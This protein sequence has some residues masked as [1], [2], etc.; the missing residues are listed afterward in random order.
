M[1]TITKSIIFKTLTLI[2]VFYVVSLKEKMY[3]YL[4]YDPFSRLT[5]IGKSKNPNKRLLSIKTSNPNAELFFYT[6]EFTEMF[7]HNKF[8]DKRQDGEWFA[9]NKI[10]I[11]QITKTYKCIP[12]SLHY[13]NTKKDKIR[14]D[15][16][17]RKNKL[18]NHFFISELSFAPNYQ[19]TTK[20]DLY[21]TKTMRKINKT[22]NGYS[23]GYWIDKKFITL[24]NLRKHLVK[25]EHINCPF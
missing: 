24:G 16:N 13:T 6:N 15:I 25:I 2:F 5:K 20:N 3:A 19:W 10:D 11:F 7:L 8:K 9:L 21:N 14:N 17:E 22:V 18:L 4:I 23:V 12:K 1:T